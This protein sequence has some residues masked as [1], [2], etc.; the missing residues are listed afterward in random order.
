MKFVQARWFTP[1]A[2][3]VIDLIVV[4]SM[5]GSEHKQRA[6]N[7]AEDFH[8]RPADRKAS[9]HYA[10]DNDSIVQCVRDMDIAYA[11]PN[12]NHNGLHFEH[13]GGHAGFAHQG[14]A[15]WLDTYGQQML[16]LSAQLA[17]EKARQ[18]NIPLIWLSPLEV[19][20]KKRG[21]TSHNN[22][23]VGFHVKHG[24]TDPGTGFPETRYM[25]M[26][27]EAYK[28]EHGTLIDANAG[29]NQPHAIVS[30]PPFHYSLTEVDK[31]KDL[32]VFLNRFLPSDM[33][34]VEDG[35]PGPSTS[36]AFQY[37]FGRR[38]KGDPRGN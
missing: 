27:R 34:L 14:E 25:D 21:F 9:A 20:A 15:E 8:T 1:V 33:R 5:E 18:Y 13:A 26:V 12:A 24:H 32:Q 23:T 17:A 6:E 7:C 22:I 3:R 37:L 2:H 19:A 11:A 4:H 28:A 29:T 31:A 16:Q 38:L 10:I 35:R 30:L 36:E